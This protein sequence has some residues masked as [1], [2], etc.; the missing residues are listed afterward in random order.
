MKFYSIF[1][2]SLLLTALWFPF[3][4]NSA[5]IYENS[6]WN[7][8]ILWSLNENIV[9][10]NEKLG[11]T[12]FVLKT[13]DESVKP[14]IFSR[15][16]INQSLSYQNSFKNW[17]LYLIKV[18]IIDPNCKDYDFYIKNWDIIYTDTKFTQ[19]NTSYSLL[20]NKFSDYNN[21]DLKEKYDEFD[22]IIHSLDNETFALKNNIEITQQIKRIQK[23]YEM[24]FD[25]FNNSIIDHIIKSRSDLKY[26]SP[27]KGR[28]LP[29]N[30]NLIPN[31]SRL[32][33]IDTTDWIHHWYD[34]LAPVWTQVQAL[35]E[36]IIVRIKKWF[37]WADFSKIKKW[38]LSFDDK[39]I[40]L[41]IFKWNQV[42][43]K[44]LDWNITIYAHLWHISDDIFEW[45]MVKAGVYL[46]NIDKTWVPDKEYKDYHLHFEM[47][48]N[49]HIKD[50]INSTLDI[51]RWSWFWEWKKYDWII[52]E[53]NKLFFY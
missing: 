47:Q 13:S 3:S 44:T 43:L 11:S 51:L 2:F 34:I 20:L 16:N 23:I 4:L 21:A 48:Q 14:S 17:K 42:W 32:Y 53:Q 6:W 37:S 30:K 45:K 25:E 40:N 10:W 41:D 9:D 24:N 35:W 8:I 12:I 49:P 19:N 38:K 29:T 26:I 39:L 46:G 33:R 7:S 27:V 50:K 1:T 36:W 31:A 22:K 28:A 52:N 15:C 18:K 5:D